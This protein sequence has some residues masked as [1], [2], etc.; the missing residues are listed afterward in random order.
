MG[1][2]LSRHEARESRS[3]HVKLDTC[4]TGKTAERQLSSRRHTVQ[5]EEGWGLSFPP[6]P[7]TC[8]WDRWKRTPQTS[9]KRELKPS[10]SLWIRA[11]FWSARCTC[12]VFIDHPNGKKSRRW[13]CGQNRVGKSDLNYATLHF[14]QAY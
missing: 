12:S 13:D 11:C 2:G 9:E 3:P 7:L 8:Y 5:G 10:S 1:A 14:V 4:L 6:A